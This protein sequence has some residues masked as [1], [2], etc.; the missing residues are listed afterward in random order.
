MLLL[1]VPAEFGSFALFE[2]DQMAGVWFPGGGLF[3]FVYWIVFSLV[4]RVLSDIYL[5]SM[6]HSR[7][8]LQRIWQMDI[9]V[10]AF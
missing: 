10:R 2:V 5:L 1:S 6:I 8:A 4:K 7:V 9:M 3:F